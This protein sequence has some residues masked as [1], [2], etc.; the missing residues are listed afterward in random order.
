[1][2][3][4][5]PVFPHVRKTCAMSTFQTSSRLSLSLTAEF[6]SKKA[7]VCSSWA[8]KNTSHSPFLY[9]NIP[10]EATFCPAWSLQLFSGPNLF[11]HLPPL[12]HQLLG[13]RPDTAP[14]TL[15]PSVEA[16]MF[17]PGSLTCPLKAS[18][19][20]VLPC[21]RS[22]LR[23]LRS[24][25]YMRIRVFTEVQKHDWVH[26]CILPTLPT[27]TRALALSTA[28]D[29]C[30]ASKILPETATFCP[31]KIFLGTGTR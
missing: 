10:N 26:F 25:T 1:M 13:V 14:P 31:W 23:L 15:L 17:Q 4:I 2:R 8:E 24:H 18:A 9:A 21:E 6:L 29:C 5:P 7:H 20:L 16:F 11:V 27:V 22:A 19:P 3:L 28:K 12:P 30:S